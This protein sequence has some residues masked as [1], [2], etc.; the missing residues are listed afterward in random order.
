MNMDCNNKTKI[1]ELVELLECPVCYISIEMESTIQCMNGHYGCD[2]CFTTLETCP[3][4]R[5]EMTKTIKSFSAE[6]IE[7][8]KREL[9]HFETNNLSFD[10]G[11]LLEIFKC[12]LCHEIPTNRPVRQCANGH[13]ECVICDVIFRPCPICGSMLDSSRARR[14]LLTEKIIS[15]F[16]MPCRFQTLGCK[17]T[18]IEFGNHE[19]EGC[20]VRPI[21]C[22][23]LDCSLLVPMKEYLNHLSEL[24]PNHSN[25][26]AKLDDNLG[27]ICNVNSGSIHFPGENRMEVL[28]LKLHNN[29]FFMLVHAA[30]F[31]DKF[32]FWVYFLGL[33]DKANEYSFKIRLYNPGS[34]K[35]I[36]LAG[37]TISVI[38]KM[39]K[40]PK[41]SL[42][43]GIP[44]DEVMSYWELNTL[45]VSY[46]V[47]VV[48]ER[49]DHLTVTKT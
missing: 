21:F 30:I 14:S 27:K 11:T 43:F 10:A 36:H 1:Q 48:K 42:Q 4:C 19:L 6:T 39:I 44:F 26:K 2:N 33:Q 12:D 15:K 29:H 41:S 23:F 18:L 22:F 8:V 34:K 9:R 24:N 37:P 3:V 25:W 16:S 35:E 49:V 46:Q 13:I 31:N 38:H 20:H 47:T 40:M 32:H 17:Q 28:Y 7:A 5:V 45:S